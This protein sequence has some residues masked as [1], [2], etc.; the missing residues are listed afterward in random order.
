MADVASEMSCAR[1][2]VA[3]TAGVSS[4]ARVTRQRGD[5]RPP[6]TYVELDLDWE[7]LEDHSSH[8]LDDFCQRGTRR[9]Q[10]AAGEE[11]QLSICA[12]HPPSAPRKLLSPQ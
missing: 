7:K 5:T 12:D 1:G 4:T 6:R 10:T 8:P 3:R 9:T 2:R 11:G